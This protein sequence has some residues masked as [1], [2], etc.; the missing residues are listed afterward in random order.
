MWTAESGKEGTIIRALQQ[1]IAVPDLSLAFTEGDAWAKAPYR[2][3]DI[4]LAA[5]SELRKKWA[6]RCK[7]DDII[8]K[9]Y[10]SPDKPLH[11]ETGRLAR[12]Q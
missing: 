6:G 12:L 11:T 9:V 8:V 7:T 4:L 1:F 3:M 2:A 5:A 10:G